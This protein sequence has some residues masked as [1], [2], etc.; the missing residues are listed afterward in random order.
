MADLNDRF[1][2]AGK[3][4]EPDVVA[5]LQSIMRMHQL[6]L[7]ALFFKWESYCIK[8]DMDEMA[9]SMEGLRAFK[10]DLQDA[11]ER[12]NRTQVHVKTEK[13]VSATPR[14][15]IKTGDVFNM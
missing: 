11:L 5:E 10:Q 12:N 8:M 1:A 6:S 9:P 14:T 13:R 15:A 4:L 2:P 7:Q 3:Q